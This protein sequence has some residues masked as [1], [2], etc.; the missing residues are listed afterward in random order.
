MKNKRKL[1]IDCDPGVDDAIAL[2]FLGANLNQFE[3]LAITTVSG[4]QTIDKVTRNALD[5]THF[6]GMDIPVSRGMEGPIV[7]RPVYARDAH[8]ESG[9][10]NVVLP[11]CNKKPVKEQGILYL[12]SVLEELPDDEE[13]TFICMGPLT[14]IAMLF[15]MFPHVK[16][17]IREIL[18]MG[19]SAL[20][21]NVTPSAEFN[22]YTDPEAAKIVVDSGVSLIM[23]GLDVTN[24]CCLTRRQIL[25]LCQSAD[26][27]AKL[28]GDMAGYYLENTSNKY[29]GMV[30]IHDAAPIMYL[31][32]PEIFKG[33]KAILDVDCSEGIS[34]GRTICDMRW[35]EHEPEK[36]DSLVIMDVDQDKFQEYLIL[37]LY[38][39]GE[40]Q[41]KCIKE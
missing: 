38:E 15:K 26:P 31:C 3:L 18:F 12:K 17:K 29:R 22:I 6:F 8:G 30:S 7:R 10:G 11:A 2:A 5:L 21:G 27:V 19:G 20:G 33:E 41:K 37:S 4:N 14:N 40:K 16:S 25:K 9:L 13:I 34:R 23:F 39:L 24:K 32:H 1:I 36:M 35:W 28:C